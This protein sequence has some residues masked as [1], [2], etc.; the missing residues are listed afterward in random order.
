MC[1]TKLSTNGG[2]TGCLRKNAGV[3]VVN[4]YS[5]LCHKNLLLRKT[6]I[7]S[8]QVLLSFIAIQWQ[9]LWRPYRHRNSTSPHT[10]DRASTGTTAITT[11]ILLCILERETIHSLYTMS[12]C[13]LRKTS[14]WVLNQ[15]SVEA[16]YLVFLCWS[17]DQDIVCPE[18][19]KQWNKNGLVHHLV[20]KRCPKLQLL[21]VGA[22]SSLAH[23]GKLHSWLWS[24]GWRRIMQF[25]PT[26]DREH[27]LL[28][29]WILT[30]PNPAIVR[31]ITPCMCKMISLGKRRKEFSRD[32]C[33][34]GELFYLECHKVYSLGIIVRLNVLHKLQFVCM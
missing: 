34:C 8:R 14:P 4:I 11:V 25:S 17:I 30:V 2:C 12:L 15:D 7:Q 5:L 27:A 6:S 29:Q 1:W 9:H 28:G 20:G 23:P 22:Q 33:C 18:K 24:C 32:S 31:F 13:T 26:C 16:N 10:Q 19:C 21:S 3:L